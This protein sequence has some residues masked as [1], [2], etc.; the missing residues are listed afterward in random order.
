MKY[1]LTLITCLI[2]VMSFG[3]TFGDEPF[4]YVENMP[5]FPGGDAGFINI[6]EK[7]FHPQAECNK[8]DKKAYVVLQFMVD[9]VGRMVNPIIVKGLDCCNAEALRTIKALSEQDVRW[10][11]GRHAGRKVNVTKTVAVKCRLNN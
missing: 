3:Q 2:A 10:S 7:E 8:E 5:S 9:T 1:I 4:T 11:P 6:Y